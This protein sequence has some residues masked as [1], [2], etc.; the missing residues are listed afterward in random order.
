MKYS[1]YDTDKYG[2]E[3]YNIE[4]DDYFN[5]IKTCF[6]YSE[7]VTFK[8]FK[9][10]N[11]V[12][13][14]PSWM[15]Q[16]RLEENLITSKSNKPDR[17]LKKKYKSLAPIAETH[18]FILS[19]PVCEWMLSITDNIWGWSNFSNPP[20]PEDPQFFRADSSLFF[21][22]ISHDGECTFYPRA[23]EDIS[24]IVSKKH[25]HKLEDDKRRFCTLPIEDLIKADKLIY[26]SLDKSDLKSRASF[27][28]IEKG[29]SIEF[30]KSID[31]HGNY[32]VDLTSSKRSVH[33]TS[34]GY[35]VTVFYDDYSTVE[36]V[37][38]DL[39]SL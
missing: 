23:Y 18:H 22:S 21:S 27:E 6:K 20:T 16:Y 17:N 15:E 32:K 28:K 31:P 26:N 34:D 36:K 19:D 10:N 5:L 38:I 13:I 11:N 7:S 1:F 4:G 39:Y 25:W 9:S 37:F 12:D 24:A 8:V 2:D 14:I 29:C 30:V 35:R 3:E 33:F